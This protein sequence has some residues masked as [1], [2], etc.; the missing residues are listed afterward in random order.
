MLEPDL[1]LPSLSCAPQIVNF[2]IVAQNISVSLLS[3]AGDAFNS[4]GHMTTITSDDPLDENSFQTP[5]KVR[6]LTV[7]PLHA[8]RSL[9]LW[10]EL[11][12]GMLMS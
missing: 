11:L 4:A 6:C 8:C 3:I 5:E 7:N 9:Y 1:N 10:G 2:D 12:E